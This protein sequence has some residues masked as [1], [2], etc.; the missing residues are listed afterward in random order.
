LLSTGISAGQSFTVTVLGTATAT[1]TV[2]SQ[3]GE[4]IENE[5]SAELFAGDSMDFVWTG[6][7]FV[8]Q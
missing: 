8:V 2:V 4:T 6:A 1:V 5:S 7:N 3:H